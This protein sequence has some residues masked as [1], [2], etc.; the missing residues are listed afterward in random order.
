MTAGPVSRLAEALRQ[1]HR[2]EPAQREELNPLT[3]YDGNL[4]RAVWHSPK[5][6]AS[7]ILSPPIRAY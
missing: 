1:F 2:Q 3:P 6:N 4:G 7:Q 5:R